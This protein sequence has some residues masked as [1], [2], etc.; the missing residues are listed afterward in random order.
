V[1]PPEVVELDKISRETRHALMLNQ[2]KPLVGA[3]R[4]HVG[5]PADRAHRQSNQLLAGKVGLAW[6]WLSRQYF[7]K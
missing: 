3:V 2:M 7:P 5:A 6:Y 4:A 1:N